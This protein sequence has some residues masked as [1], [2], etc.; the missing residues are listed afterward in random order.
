M[1]ARDYIIGALC[2]ALLVTGWQYRKT[3]AKLTDTQKTLAVAEA[4]NATNL[5]AIE[6]LERSIAATDKVVSGWNQDRQTLAG[7]RS[8]TKQAI[9]EAMR[10]ETFK[11]WANALVHPDAIRLFNAPI[12]A[13]G[14]DS[15]GATGGAD[16]RLPGNAAP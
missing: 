5:K 8:A 6:R 2:L 11:A 9:R 14:N 12:G 4:A 7:V 10:D 16:G 13:D 15:A 3:D 1:T